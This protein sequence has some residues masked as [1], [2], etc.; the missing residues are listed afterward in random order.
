MVRKNYAKNKYGRARG[1]LPRSSNSSAQ[2]GRD[3][4]SRSQS[5]E[6]NPPNR[7]RSRSPVGLSSPLEDSRDREGTSVH[8]TISCSLPAVDTSN[9]N[10]PSLMDVDIPAPFSTDNHKRAINSNSD[11]DRAQIKPLNKIQKKIGNTNSPVEKS[12]STV[13]IPAA[14]TNVDKAQKE[15]LKYSKDARLPYAVHV[16]YV[17]KTTNRLLCI[18]YISVAFSHK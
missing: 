4:G 7:L 18:L 17:D 3:R 9:K 8:V 15:F 12:N 14:S 16:R 6:S 2:S 13:N 1:G 10:I 11:S 5:R